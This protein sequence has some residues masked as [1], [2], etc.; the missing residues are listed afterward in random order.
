MSVDSAGQAL[1]IRRSH[2]STSA[3]SSVFISMSSPNRLARRRPPA[4]R[5][6]LEALEFETRRDRATHQRPGAERGRAL[7]PAGRHHELRPLPGGEIGADMMGRGV[8]AIGRYGDDQRRAGIMM[9]DLGRI[10]AMPLRGLAGI[11]QII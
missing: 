6:H 11:E 2:P 5:R 9:P 7:P 10:D 1:M 3:L 8:M 4:R